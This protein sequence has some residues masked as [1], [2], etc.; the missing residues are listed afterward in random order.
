MILRK[1]TL[2]ILR[3]AT[4]SPPTERYACLSRVI[5]ESD[6]KKLTDVFENF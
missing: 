5:K 6:D 2:K 1:G 3:D 4:F